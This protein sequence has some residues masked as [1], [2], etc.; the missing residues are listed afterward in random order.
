MSRLT[1]SLLTGALLFAIAFGAEAETAAEILAKSDAAGLARTSMVKMTQ[2]VVTPG[3]DSRT[4]KI[5]AY[6][7]NG[8]E[9][10]LTVYVAPSQVKGMKIL[11][12]NDGDDIWSYFPRTNR[13]RK[14]ASS[15]R[16]RKVQ[17]SDFTYDDMAGGKMAKNWQGEVVGSEKV[18]GIDCFKLSLVPTESGPKSY[19]KITAWVS[20]ADYTSVRVEYF[21]LD[22]DKTKRLDIRNYKKISEVY[23]PFEY[24]M[25]NLMDGGKTTM[26]VVAAKVNVD[27]EPGLF[28]E[29]SL[30]K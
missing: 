13:T 12:L 20:K 1:L 10:G 22:G 7:S 18:E 9:K 11:T 8:N 2:T 14:I 17:G 6:A 3:G 5:L 26:K 23:V 27:L 28:T 30:A 24:T 25:T 16:N 4:F 29:A 15:A 19:S 21:D